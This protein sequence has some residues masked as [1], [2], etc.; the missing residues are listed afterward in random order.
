MSK[1]TVT[2]NAGT[3]YISSPYNP[4]FVARIKNLGGRWDAAS[5]AWKI[6][7]QALED[8]RQI[9]RDTYGETDQP[10]TE[11]T[12]TLRVEITEDIWELRSPI[13]IAGRIVAS[14][15]GRDSG[16]RAGEDVAFIEGKPQSGGSAKNWRTCIDAGSIIKIFNAPVAKARDVIANP[17]YDGMVCTILDQSVTI[18][19]AALEAERE[20]LLARIA[21]IDTLLNQ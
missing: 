18:N 16:A 7:E 3:A 11:P 1:I 13:V 12:V 21:E 10:T 5:H 4:E 15:S 8:A 9:M 20:K 17:P 2:L 19:R 6:S 14:A